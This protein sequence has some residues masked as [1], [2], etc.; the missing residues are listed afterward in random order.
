[1]NVHRVITDYSHKI[2]LHFCHSH[3]VN[4]LNESAENCY[5]DGVTTIGVPFCGMK[6]IQINAIEI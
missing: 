2:K 3:R 4:P 6:G 1:M 5:V